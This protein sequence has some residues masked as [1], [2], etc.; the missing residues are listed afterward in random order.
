MPPDAKIELPFPPWGAMTRP[1][2]WLCRLRRHRGISMEL[3]TERPSPTSRKIT[4]VKATCNCGREQTR[5]RVVYP[6]SYKINVV[7]DAG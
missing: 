6:P 1:D 5:V 2:H 4:V 7:P 3:E